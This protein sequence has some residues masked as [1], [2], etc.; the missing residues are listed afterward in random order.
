MNIILIKFISM[1]ILNKEHWVKHIFIHVPKCEG[2]SMESN[3]HI[4]GSGHATL[5]EIQAENSEENF[6]DYFKWTFIRNPF[7]RVASVWFKMGDELEKEK[8]IKSECKNLKDFVLKLPELVCKDENTKSLDPYENILHVQPLDFFIKFQG[9]EMDFIG[10]FE[11]LKNDYKYVCDKLQI[12][13]HITHINK[14]RAQKSY[15]NLYNDKMKKII[16]DT[17]KSDLE[18][19]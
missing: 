18:Y 19:Y 10:K 16:M 7:D 1:S 2:S 4:G 5:Y 12:V 15:L 8:Q 3:L 11:N 17:Y 13:N 6:N 9:V 14:S